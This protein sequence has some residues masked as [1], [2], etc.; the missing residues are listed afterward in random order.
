MKNM[1]FQLTPHFSFDEFVSSS[2][3]VKYRINNIPSFEVVSNITR[4]AFMLESLRSHVG[5][6]FTINSGYRCPRLNTIL[7]GVRNSQHLKGLAADVS[8]ENFSE[9]N[10]YVF[11]SVLRG[12]P[13]D[14]CIFEKS[15]I[16]I[17]VSAVN[18]LPRQQLLYWPEKYVE[19]YLSDK[20]F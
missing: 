2:T 11:L 18:R 4:L 19:H 9:E 6:P 12:L 13:F 5:I 20:P 3:A 17:S 16:H 8:L 1:C 7:C 10:I 15:F 14:Q